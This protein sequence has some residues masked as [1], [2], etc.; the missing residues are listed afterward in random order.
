[1]FRPYRDNN[2]YCG[3]LCQRKARERRR[4][5]E[6]RSELRECSRCGVKNVERKPGIAV[7]D[8]CRVDKRDRTEFERRRRFRTY[9]ITEAQYDAMF[10]RQG[11][12]C[13]ICLTDTPGRKGWAI[14]HCHDSGVVRGVLCSK[15]NS[16]IGLLQDDPAVIMRAALYVERHQLAKAS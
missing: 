5:G 13:G 7:C 2:L 8:G 11:Y 9:G 10:E 4:F 1:M 6:L 16:A 3:R 12:R 15:C 14:D